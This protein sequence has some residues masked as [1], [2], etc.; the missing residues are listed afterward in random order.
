MEVALQLPT[1]IL[2]ILINAATYMFSAMH[3]EPGVAIV[4]LAAVIK[5]AN[6]RPLPSVSH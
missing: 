6:E 1:R 2:I 5:A 4:G 3:T